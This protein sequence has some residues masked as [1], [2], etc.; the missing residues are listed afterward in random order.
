MSNS[1]LK[2]EDEPC[3]AVTLGEHIRDARKRHGWTISEFAERLGRAREWLNRV[4]LG[5]SEFGEYKP[6]SRVEIEAMFELIGDK[7]DVTLEWL[8]AVGDLATAEYLEAKMQTEKAKRTTY[9]KLT[10]TE[11]VVG[12]K[13]IVAAIA[14]L[15]REQHSEAIIRN[16][17]VKNLGSYQRVND[18]W[19]QYRL[20]LGEFLSKNPNA[21]FKRIEYAATAEQLQHAKDA[22][23][24]IAGDRALSEV[25]N[26]KIKFGSQNPLQLHAVI[27]QHEAILALPQTSG[28]AGS[29]VALLIRDKGFVEALRIWYDEVMWDMPG[30]SKVVNFEKFDESFEEIKDMYGFPESD[31]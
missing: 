1:N 21:L 2:Q 26:A 19:R 23:A 10:Q 9:G 5:Y 29:N 31:G 3:S 22:D 27:G 18:N 16:T 8:V 25:H 6:A 17:G 12:E 30:D 20:A 7:M 24:K 13:Q 14:Q 28:Q 4:E 15:I 11:V